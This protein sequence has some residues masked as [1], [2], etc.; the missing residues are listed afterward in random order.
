MN[1]TAEQPTVTQASELDAVIARLNARAAFLESDVLV[2]S[3]AEAARSGLFSASCD[4]LPA[5]LA[6][7][8]AGG[9][10]RGELD[11]NA[12]RGAVKKF[13]RGSAVVYSR[14]SIEDCIRA[15]HWKNRKSK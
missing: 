2:G 4:L 14:K 15:G 8:A 12:K 3:L 1:E 6:C 5:H 13:D 10:G 9:C 7:I 11:F